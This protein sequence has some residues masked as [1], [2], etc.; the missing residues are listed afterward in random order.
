MQRLLAIL[1]A[2]GGL[3][4]APAGAGAAAVAKT[5]PHGTVTVCDRVHKSAVFEGRMDTTPRTD[6]M[7][8]RFRLQVWTP[9]A[10]AWTRLAVPGFSAWVTSDPGRTRYVYSKRV[11]SLLAPAAYRVITRFRWLDARGAT[12]R[13][14][15]TISKPCR[16][17]DPRPDLRVS[18]LA[19]APAADGSGRRYDVTVRNAGR[20]DA[21]ASTLHLVLA[22]GSTLPA[23]VPPIAPG[24]REDVFVSGPACRS[25]EMLTAIADVA[26]AV[27]ERDEANAFS[28][29][30]PSS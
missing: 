10:P 27:D 5:P 18:G 3:A 14:A 11:E 16:Q 22:D 28:F 6:R 21:A 19:L 20:S 25:G 24:G 1:F 29:P 15:Q 23:D 2:A 12:L 8:M 26:D 9:D 7:Q 13:T 30:C 17:P 4:L